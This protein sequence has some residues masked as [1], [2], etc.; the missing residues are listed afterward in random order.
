[1]R[2]WT[3]LRRLECRVDA[4]QVREDSAAVEMWL[5]GIGR[6]GLPPGSSYMFTVN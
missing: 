3:H 5:S 1:M 2:I 4:D 6:S